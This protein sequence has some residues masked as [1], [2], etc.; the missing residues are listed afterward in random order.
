MNTTGLVFDVQRC[1]LNDG[2]GIRTAV[3]L[4][5][6]TLRCLWCHNPEAISSEP[7]LSFDAA[8]CIHCFTCVDVC[9]NGAQR[10]EEGKH[11]LDHAACRA[12]GQCIPAC[13]PGALRLIGETRS[14]EEIVAEVERDADYYR[15][16]GGGVTLTGGEPMDQFEFTL[17]VLRACKD[18]GIHT[19]IE[20]NGVAT[21]GRYRRILPLVDVFLF[22]YKATDPQKHE[23]LTG[24]S[25]ERILSNLELLYRHGAA[26]VLRCP[27]VP[28]VN[29][30]PAHM[31]GIARLVATHPRLAGI[32][33]MPY[34]E[35]GVG[36]GVRVGRP[37]ALEGI[38]TTSEETRGRWIENL[39]DLGCTA[40]RLG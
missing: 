25:N 29:D 24:A 13:I 16:S 8:R 22:D 33:V 34:H 6:C 1:S 40:A 3:F 11:V 15:A 14:V 35:L 5:G 20:T 37:R 4:K 9:P 31:E 17:Q 28:G 12:C 19:C 21:P 32:E 23:E 39:H 36:K 2:P 7:Q 38:E 27:L 26:I 30:P 10:I 18:R